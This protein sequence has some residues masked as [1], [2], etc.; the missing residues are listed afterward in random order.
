M[1]RPCVLS[2]GYGQRSTL[3]RSFRMNNG[4]FRSAP[5]ASKR[6][7]PLRCKSPTGRNPASTD[8][9]LSSNRRHNLVFTKSLGSFHYF[10]R[11]TTVNYLVTAIFTGRAPI[12]KAVMLCVAVGNNARRLV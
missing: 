1:M 4:S 7:R 5:P 10:L 11:P 8:G 9:L 3:R 2:I 6:T 12:W